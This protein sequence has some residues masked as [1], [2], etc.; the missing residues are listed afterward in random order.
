MSITKKDYFDAMAGTASDDVV[1]AVVAELE[2]EGSA[3]RAVLAGTKSWCDSRL[4]SV[5]Q[6]D[7]PSQLADEN[8]GDESA[9]RKRQRLF[10]RKR[11]PIV[12]AYLLYLQGKASSEMIDG[13]REA[14]LDFDSDLSEELDCIEVPRKVIGI[15]HRRNSLSR[16]NAS[17]E[18]PQRT[19]GTPD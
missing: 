5:R 12:E 1:A 17:G 7:W 4:C 16:P 2:N 14:L 10:H 9:G 8:P 6:R 18:I 11:P 13:V 3:L 15:R 19:D